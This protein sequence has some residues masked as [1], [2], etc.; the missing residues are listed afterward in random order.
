MLVTSN[1]PSNNRSTLS[2]DSALGYQ[3]EVLQN[4]MQTLMQCFTNKKPQSHLTVTSSQPVQHQF[5]SGVQGVSN[6]SGNI[7]CTAYS[8]SSTVCISDNV[9]ILDTRVT[10]HMCCDLSH[11]HEVKPIINPFSV[12][13]PNGEQALVTHSGS[14]LL[15]SISIFLLDVLYI[16]TF[17]F[18]LLSISKLSSQIQSKIWF[19]SNSCYLQDQS[20][21]KTLVLGN[22]GGV[23]IYSL[24]TL[25]HSIL[26]LQ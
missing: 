24:L 11:M 4:Q 13:F 6:F 3:M 18:N 8:L 15:H 16:P 22:L 12:I 23:Y 9:W 17:T 1:E 20:Q 26:S 25:H 2:D 5:S 10:N 7:A 21:K 14:V 19:Q